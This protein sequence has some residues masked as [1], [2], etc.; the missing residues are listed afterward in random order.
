[1]TKG[2]SRIRLYVIDDHPI[3]LEGVRI[4]IHG[5]NDMEI[6]GEA[7][8]AE[9]LFRQLPECSPDVVL[10]DLTLPGLGGLD[11]TRM[12]TQR[13]PEMKVIILT[14]DCEVLTITTALQAGAKGSISKAA[15]GEDLIQAIRLVHRGEEFFSQDVARKML[16]S[17]VKNTRGIIES[18]A[19]L[20]I[21]SDREIGILR[22]IADGLTYKEIGDKLSI[23]TRT[24]ETHRNNISQKL[25]LSTNADLIKYSIRH[26]I[27]KL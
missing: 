3:I 22:L 5:I 16:S 20:T 10:M 7:G 6:V 2:K 23:S 9:D 12:L 1:M 25:K 11:A 27:A 19:P 21:L 13:H 24:V 15:A 17:Y 26:G 4:T 14:A 18:D 8:N